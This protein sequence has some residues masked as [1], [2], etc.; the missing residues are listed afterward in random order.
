MGGLTIWHWI[1]VI[2]AFLVLWYIWNR[3]FRR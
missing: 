1:V 2:G 3:Y